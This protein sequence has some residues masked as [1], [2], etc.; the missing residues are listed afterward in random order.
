[1]KL[2][3]FCFNIKISFAELFEHFIDILAVYRHVIGVDEYIIKV[4]HNTNIQKIGKYVIYK[5]LKGYRG[6]GKAKWYYSLLK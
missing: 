6:I 2:T 3:L 1:M 4:D 5:L